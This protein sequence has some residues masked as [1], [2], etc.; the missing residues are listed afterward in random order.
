MHFKTPRN[1]LDILLKECYTRRHLHCVDRPYH[2]GY[3][4]DATSGEIKDVAVLGG[5]IT[6]LAT[7]FYL[8]E[9]L[10]HKRISLFE[11]SSRLGGWLQ[12]TSVDVGTGKVVFEQGPRNLRPKM[13]NGF[14]TIDLVCTGFITFLS[15]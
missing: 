8:S 13:P 3:A 14:V 7:A 1:A 10:P 2:R 12:S 9:S 6:G 5:G 11:A 4:S 15:Y